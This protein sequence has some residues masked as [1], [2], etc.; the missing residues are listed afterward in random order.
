MI[1]LFCIGSQ[2]DAKELKSLS[3]KPLLMAIML[4]AAVIPS[5]Y[6]LVKYF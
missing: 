2:F 5:A 6:L 1:G 3:G 4:W